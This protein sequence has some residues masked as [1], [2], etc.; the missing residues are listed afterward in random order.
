[1]K[2]RRVSTWGRTD[3]E[4]AVQRLA[5]TRYMV[6]L[7][8][9]RATWHLPPGSL[10]AREGILLD[11]ASGRAPSKQLTGRQYEM[12]RA[13]A[14]LSDGA[15]TLGYEHPALKAIANLSSC[16]VHWRNARFHDEVWNYNSHLNVFML[17]LSCVD[18][19]ERQDNGREMTPEVAAL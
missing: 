8:M 10:F 13:L 12:L 6:G 1:M 19:S 3:Q 11:L 4:D 17:V 5:L 15:W 7:A 16:A 18:L 9:I 2:M 14:L